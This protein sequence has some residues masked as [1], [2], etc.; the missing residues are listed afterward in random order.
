MATVR[1]RSNSNPCEVNVEVTR[2]ICIEWQDCAIAFISG[3]FV[4][5]E[6]YQT[7]GVDR[8]DKSFLCTLLSRGPTG[9][10]CREGGSGRLLPRGLQAGSE[11]G[12]W[13]GAAR[14]RRAA[15]FPVGRLAGSEGGVWRRG[16]APARRACWQ[17]LR[18]VCGGAARRGHE[19]PAGRI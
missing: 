6:C 4:C 9:R 11:G 15:C 14:A 18:V 13:R 1:V 10:I 8:V 19:G 3:L 17:D 7:M 12:V 2:Y 16:A 5:S